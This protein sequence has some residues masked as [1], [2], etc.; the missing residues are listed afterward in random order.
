[1]KMQMISILDGRW[2]WHW[3]D[4]KVMNHPTKCSLYAQ[5]GPFNGFSHLWAHTFLPIHTLQ[6]N[7]KMSGS[8]TSVAN[9]FWLRMFCRYV[10]FTKLIFVSFNVIW[11]D[12]LILLRWIWVLQHRGNLNEFNQKKRKNEEIVEGNDYKGTQSTIL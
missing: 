4:T 2:L 10:F 5:V 9:W 1:M 11:P 3:Y 6:S 12:T 8:W 7:M